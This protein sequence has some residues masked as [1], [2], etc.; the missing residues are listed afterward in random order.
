MW[1][2][3]IQLQQQLVH[4]Q[5]SLWAALTEEPHTGHMLQATRVSEVVTPW[6]RCGCKNA[7]FTA[8]SFCASAWVSLI[9]P[10]DCAL[11][12]V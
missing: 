8:V 1:A 3:G 2:L 4:A 10:A 7:C 6:H 9:S 11:L 12:C 5:S